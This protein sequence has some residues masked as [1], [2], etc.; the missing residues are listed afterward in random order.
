MSYLVSLLLYSNSHI[1]GNDPTYVLN[2][3]LAFK[4]CVVG[5]G[6][7]NKL[8]HAFYSAVNVSVY[9]L[10][11]VSNGRKFILFKIKIFELVFH[12]STFNQL[13]I[14]CEQ[15]WG[16]IQSMGGYTGFLISE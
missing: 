12:S 6:F 4:L 3:I 11:F 8:T 13:I 1:Q 2:S 9:T 14:V 7:G 16:N 15:A 10:L 5:C